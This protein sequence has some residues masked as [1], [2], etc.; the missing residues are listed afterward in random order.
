MS[1]AVST[2]PSFTD[3]ETHKLGF[4]AC[5]DVTLVSNEAI[6]EYNDQIKKYTF[7]KGKLIQLFDKPLPANMKNCRKAFLDNGHIALCAYSNT[8]LY[9]SQFELLKTH[10]CNRGRLIGGLGSNL[11]A[12]RSASENNVKI[13]NIDQDHKH[14][15][16]LV[17]YQ[18]L[19]WNSTWVSI[20]RHSSSG[21]ME[22][23]DHS[24]TS[25]CI[26]NGEGNITDVHGSTIVV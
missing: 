16:T 19:T 9:N 13:Y 6:V 24:S 25:V 15:M 18:V 1:V 4:N 2:A 22:I 14:V 26:Y 20:C 12:Y 7:N 10:D 23:V 17:P 21:Y 8:Y 11:L 3:H 5:W